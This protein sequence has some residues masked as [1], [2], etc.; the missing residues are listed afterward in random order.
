MPKPR[1]AWGA[2]P[3]EPATEAQA[4]MSWAS[5]QPR[6]RP[7]RSA[8]WP[9]RWFAAT[10][11]RAEQAPGPETMVEPAAGCLARR[12]PSPVSVLRPPPTPP[13]GAAAL[14]RAALR[15]E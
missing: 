8:A 11:D 7:P 1:A 15:V 3:W 4:A 12:P 6:P 14:A 9:G 5:P 2:R 10:A 13:V